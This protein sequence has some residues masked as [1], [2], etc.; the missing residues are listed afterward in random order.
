MLRRF[1]KPHRSMREADGRVGFLF[2]FTECDMG[3]DGGLRASLGKISPEYTTRSPFLLA[4]IGSTCKQGKPN[5][6]KNG[7]TTFTLGRRRS[8]KR[9]LTRLKAISSEG[10]LP[11]S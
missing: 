1:V 4:A 10:C 11:S 8:K 6:N 2:R 5:G 3:H 7:G 9:R